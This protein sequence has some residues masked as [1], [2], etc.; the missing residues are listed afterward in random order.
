MNNKP[1]IIRCDSYRTDEGG[2]IKERTSTREGVLYQHGTAW[3]IKIPAA[4]Y[5]MTITNPEGLP[6]IDLQN[7]ATDTT[8]QQ[9]QF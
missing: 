3:I 2:K 6:V 4:N 8:S 5:I 1:M 7:N 9:D